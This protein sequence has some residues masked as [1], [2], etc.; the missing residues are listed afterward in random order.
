MKKSIVKILFKINQRLV[1][2][3]PNEKDFRKC[4][5]RF[6]WII[7]FSHKNSRDVSQIYCFRLIFLDF[8]VIC[9]KMVNYIYSNI[10]F[11]QILVFLVTIIYFLAYCTK[12]FFFFLHTLQV[13]KRKKSRVLRLFSRFQKRFVSGFA[14]QLSL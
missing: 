14:A 5:Q 11:L 1:F 7:I 3:S 13:E 8:S 12:A 6:T 9:V 2:N 4:K 10:P